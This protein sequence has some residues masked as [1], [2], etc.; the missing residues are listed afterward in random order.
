[1]G[2]HLDQGVVERRS[3]P[4]EE[5]FDGRSTLVDLSDAMLISTDVYS[6]ISL[7][8]TGIVELCSSF[9][10][11]PISLVYGIHMHGD[12]SGMQFCDITPVLGFGFQMKVHDLLGLVLRICLMQISAIPMVLFS[13]GLFLVVYPVDFF[14]PNHKV[15]LYPSFVSS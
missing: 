14:S 4:E 8:Y 12:C 15:S 5:W 10:P 11:I 2:Q 13:T 6:G 1:M 3:T 9:M 7:T